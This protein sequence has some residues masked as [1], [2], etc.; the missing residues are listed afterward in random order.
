V[1]PSVGPR[2]R[3]RAIDD[4]P[5]QFAVSDHDGPH[6]HM[7]AADPTG[8]YV[9]A[10][11]AGLDLTL[12]WRFDPQ[13]GRLLPAD[14][15]VVS[16]PSGSAPR[17]FV[18]HP[19]GRIFYNL[20]EHDAKVAVYDYDGTQGKLKLKQIITTLPPKFAG[21]NLASEIL[22][23][24]DGRFLYI[25]NRIHNAL[26]VFAVAA[27]GQLR[28]NSETWAH[29]DN[30]RSAAID[31]SGAFFFSCNQKGDSITSF[32][33]NGANGALQFTGRFEPVGSPAS[34]IMLRPR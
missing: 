7:V 4:Q 17:H 2:H 32:R 15:P 9:I 27:D 30:P 28:M 19:N 24:A 5:G 14:V 26:A 12:V 23:T 1:R 34:M 18:F 25:S 10:D 16:A 20:Y 13:A 33:I 3:A 21:S 6:L 29:A 31:P 22:I 11:D 8:Q